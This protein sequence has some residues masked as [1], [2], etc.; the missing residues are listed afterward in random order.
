[1][2]VYFDHNASAPL[3]EEALN[4]MLPFMHN[5]HGNASSLHKS[6]R[7]LRSAI[8]SARAQVAATVNA[9]AA[10]VIFTAGGSEANNLA[11]KGMVSDPV[12]G[13]IMCSSI[14]HASVLE[15]LAQMAAAGWHTLTLPVTRDGVL[16]VAQTLNL[17]DQHKPQL[18][19]VQ[20]AN[21][22]SG[23]LQPIADLMDGLQQMEQ[24]PLIHSDASQAVGRI[25]V[26]IKA[27][28]VDLLTISAHKFQGPQGCGALILNNRVKLRH[29]LVSGGPQE[30]QRRAG[31]GNVAVMVGMG[32]AAETV[33][34]NLRERQAY[35]LELR[36]Y[37]EQQLMGIADVHIFS[38]NCERLPNTSFFSIPFYHGETLL[39]QLD[40]AGFEL[41]SGSACHSEVTRP[42]HVLSAMGVDESLA[43]NA[44]RISFG[45]D[46]SRQ[47]IDKMVAVLQDLIN[48]I[49]AG[50]R[51]AAG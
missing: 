19:S 4:S 33:Q 25:P 5:T 50:L 27:L 9:A 42:S 46:N 21:N 29:P 14:E 31:T 37:F 48:Q 45:M 51:Q 24:R 17:I 22:E 41:A 10:D 8:E 36:R 18:V 43:L 7:F 2:S 35:L 11:I 44:I 26:D 38:G 16:D 12:K 1:M 47:Q 32:K 40:Q 34:I 30:S 28:K 3:H 13:G 49:P 39:M 6:G 20:L 23:A 15:P